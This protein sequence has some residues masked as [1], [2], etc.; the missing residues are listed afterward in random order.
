MQWETW[1]V[2]AFKAD[3]FIPGV[4]S[5]GSR[6]KTHLLKRKQPVW[7]A[8]FFVYLWSFFSYQIW[9]SIKESNHRE[10]CLLFFLSPSSH[11]VLSL[12]IPLISS[13]HPSSVFVALLVVAAAKGRTN[14]YFGHAYT[15]QLIQLNHHSFPLDAVCFEAAF[16]RWGWGKKC[17]S[18][19]H[20]LNCDTA[21]CFFRSTDKLFVFL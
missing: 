12:Y 11:N 8:I 14:G 7:C 3:S 20:A 16:S 15:L 17:H 1:S 21:L 18:T 9:C 13:N 5:L 6:V 10:N 19:V 2:V 4:A